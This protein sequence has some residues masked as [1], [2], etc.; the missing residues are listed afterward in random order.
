MRPDFKFQ[1]VGPDLGL[2][3]S[4]RVSE[5]DTGWQ[6]IKITHKSP[7]LL[8]PGTIHLSNLNFF[9]SDGFSLTHAYKC[10]KDTI[11]GYDWP[12]YISRGHRS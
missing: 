9:Y 6:R 10:S 5:D 8:N 2:N 12:L 11:R 7:A 4:P 3:C 1:T